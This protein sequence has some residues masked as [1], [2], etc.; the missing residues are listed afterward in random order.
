MKSF[1]VCILFFQCTWAY[2]VEPDKVAHVVASAAI[3]SAL[4]LAMSA[5]TGRSKQVRKESI[6]AASAFALAAGLAKE[7]VDSMDNGNRRIDGGDM[8][9]NLL[10]IGVAV[11][12]IYLLD[13]HNVKATPKGIA[14]G[15]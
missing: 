14:V 1:V 2:A 4:Y 7:T 11:G 15:F 8:A 9:A 12:T 13:I 3:T 6:V 5:I 10:G